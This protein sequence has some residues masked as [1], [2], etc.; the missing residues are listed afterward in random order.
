MSKKYD[1]IIFDLDG[2]LWCA[3]DTCMKSIEYMKE[4]HSDITR[5]ITKED[6][7]AAMGKTLEEIADFYYGYLPKEKALAYTKERINKNIEF[8]TKDGGT[9]YKNVKDTII[10]LSKNY[11]L[12]IVSNCLE[13]YIEAFLNTSGLKEYFLDFENNGRTGLS[14]GENI[15]LVIQRN[16]L[17][18]A[19]Y[20][21][22]T[23]SDKKASKYSNI[24]FIYAAYGFGQVD[25][26]DYI[27][28]D[29]SEL[30]SI[31]N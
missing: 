13:G 25:E 31:L 26:Y 9:L 10:E 30:K 8:L 21:G 29:I 2:T 15:N 12:Y 24:P 16:N 20:V 1:A 7:M 6:I 3:I 14:K 11:K 27:I 19:I 4:K 28:K 23:T 17:K 22:D 18:N 5:D